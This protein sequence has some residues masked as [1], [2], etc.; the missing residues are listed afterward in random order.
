[1]SRTVITFIEH[2]QNITYFT[3]VI[4]TLLMHYQYVNAITSTALIITSKKNGC[5]QS[6]RTQNDHVHQSPYFILKMNKCLSCFF[7]FVCF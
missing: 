3:C 4:N 6:E 2:I 7:L 5:P 1:M